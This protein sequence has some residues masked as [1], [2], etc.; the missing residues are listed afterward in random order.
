M[1][2]QGLN[3]IVFFA[4][5]EADQTTQ[6]PRNAQEPSAWSSVPLLHAGP[7]RARRAFWASAAPGNPDQRVCLRD[8]AG[9]RFFPTFSAICPIGPEAYRDAKPK[10]ALGPIIVAIDLEAWP[11]PVFSFAASLARAN[12]VPLVFVHAVP[13][14]LNVP[15]ANLDAISFTPSFSAELTARTLATSRRHM[16]EM[17][18]AQPFADL[19]PQIVV[20]T[21]LPADVIVRTAEVKQAGMIVMGARQTGVPSMATHFP[22]ATAS[23]VL[24]EAPCPVMTIRA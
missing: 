16:E 22:G 11:H 4:D 13:A 9:R 21:G 8:I 10:P 2:D 15:E 17:I 1:L 12:H 6:R 24:C 5:E 18:S 23:A 7:Q 14:T 19:Q 20:E 3:E